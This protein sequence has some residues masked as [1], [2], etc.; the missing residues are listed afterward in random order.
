MCIGV[1]PVC[2]CT[3][4]CVSGAR[5]G[6]QIPRKW[7][8]RQMWAATWVLG[9]TT[10][11]P[12]RA[13]TS[14]APPLSLAQSLSSRRY[15]WPGNLRSLSLPASTHWMTS[16]ATMPAFLTW[17]WELN[18]CLEEFLAELCDVCPLPTLFWNRILI[19][20]LGWLRTFFCLSSHVL[21]LQVCTTTPRFLLKSFKG[22]ICTNIKFP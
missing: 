2:V 3:T 6:S 8:C 22:R 11:S 20:F 5:R 1:L 16:T 7:S 17:A 19:S 12:D 10:G 18:S 15:S 14:P 9:I 4:T 21:G 13:A